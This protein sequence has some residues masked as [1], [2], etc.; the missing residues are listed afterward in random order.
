MALT[1]EAMMDINRVPKLKAMDMPYTATSICGKWTPS[2][3]CPCTTIRIIPESEPRVH[4]VMGTE[5]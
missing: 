2:G 5:Q 1:I 4:V 3:N